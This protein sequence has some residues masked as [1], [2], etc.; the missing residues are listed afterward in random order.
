MNLNVFNENFDEDELL[1]GHQRRRG[2][3]GNL[4]EH[5]PTMTFM[6]DNFKNAGVDNQDKLECR[7]CMTE[8][9]DGDTLRMLTC[10]HHFHK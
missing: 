8:F 7:I 6:K 10:M 4:R 2:G 1:E 5:L 3:L 9:E